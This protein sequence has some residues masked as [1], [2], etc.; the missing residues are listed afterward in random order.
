MTQRIVVKSLEELGEF[1]HLFVAEPQS[2]SSRS[3]VPLPVE[4]ETD[5]E[6]LGIA[7]AQAAQ[8]LSE[9]AAAD[10][11]ARRQAEEAI[12]EYRR[13]GSTVSRLQEVA[14]ETQ[15]LAE[16]ATVLADE[17]FDASCRERARAVSLTARQIAE[18][19]SR[20]ACTGKMRRTLLAAR[21]DVVRLLAEE[22][23]QEEALRREEEER[24]RKDRLEEVIALAETLVA[25][26]KTNE[27]ERTLGSPGK[28][29][30]NDPAQASRLETVRRKIWAVKTGQV[31]KAL[32]QARC[33]HRKEPRQALD[34][35]EPLDLDGM[36][37]SLVRQIYGCWLQACRRLKLSDAVHYAP[38]FGRGA[39]LVPVE[40]SRLEVVAAIG[41]TRWQAGRRFSPVALRG[42]RPLS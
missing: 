28:V 36:P 1:S 11:E 9:L 40:D 39:V 37:E 20:Q 35:L 26:G 16:R 5:I 18:T 19:A 4:P 32:R 3:L 17:A 10:R 41:M 14:F 25:E 21:P 42:A 34:I 22:R 12:A 23:A 7:A 2:D 24:R 27:A 15:T 13:L 8:E 30:P 33:L 31:E 29:D 38:S 6:R